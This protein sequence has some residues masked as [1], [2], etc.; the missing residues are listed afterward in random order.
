MLTVALVETI[1]PVV[2]DVIIEVGLTLSGVGVGFVR[3][4]GLL[5]MP[6]PE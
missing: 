5:V 6:H 1:A 2:G 3:M 4:L